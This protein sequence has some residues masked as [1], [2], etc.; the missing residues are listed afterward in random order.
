MILTR[1]RSETREESTA[2]FELVNEGKKSDVRINFLDVAKALV[3]ICEDVHLDVV[4]SISRR[5]YKSLIVLSSVKDV[6]SC[7]NMFK[8]LI[9]AYG[10]NVR[11][12]EV[13]CN[14]AVVKVDPF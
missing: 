14:D 13:S 3:R 6:V 10:Y 5:G 4:T 7:K 11:V 12:N 1:S 2:C 9:A 8:V